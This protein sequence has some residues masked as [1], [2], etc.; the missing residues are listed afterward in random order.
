MA[1][2]LFAGKHHSKAYP[3]TEE[4]LQFGTEVCGVVNRV[5]C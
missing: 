5:P 4:L 2:K 1:L 3:T